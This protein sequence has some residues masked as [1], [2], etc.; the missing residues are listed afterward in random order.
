MN[1]LDFTLTGVIAAGTFFGIL[2]GPLWQIY[3]ISSIAVSVA[4]AILFHNLIS[5]ILGDIFSSKV[6]NIV[7]YA[8]AF[9]VVL[10]ITYAIGG[11]FRRFLTKRKFGINGRIIGGGISFLK[12]GLICWIIIAGISLYGNDQVRG[13][14]D[15]SIIANNFDKG[16]RAIVSRYSGN[17]KVKPIVEED[18][19]D[20]K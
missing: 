7:G 17:I 14:I 9:S 8:V 19:S 10:I 11:Q 13:I 3:R 20:K 18:S 2:T 1:W 5:N 16:A 6:S 15:N 4:A 12:T